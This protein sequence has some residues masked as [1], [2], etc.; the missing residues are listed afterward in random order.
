MDV[1]VQ[2][3]FRAVARLRE[4][5]IAFDIAKTPWPKWIG[6]S[7][8]DS[9]Q[10]CFKSWPYGGPEPAACGVAEVVKHLFARRC[11]RRSRRAGPRFES[12]SGLTMSVATHCKAGQLILDRFVPRH[13]SE[14]VGWV[15]SEF[16]LLWLA[17]NTQVPLT[18]EKV[19]GWKNRGGT[20]LIARRPDQ[21]RLIG[22]GELNPMKGCAGHVWLGHVVLHP[23]ARGA[24]LGRV[25]VGALLDHA[26]DGLGA[27]RVSLVVFPE[28]RIAVRCYESVGFS[29]I[30][31]EH[32]H[33]STS[34]V[35]H[36]LL[37][38]EAVPPTERVPETSAAPRQGVASRVREGFKRF[39]SATDSR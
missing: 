30:G 19:I 35:R 15:K 33:F 5:R 26:F 3:Q 11:R 21:T 9:L 10:S 14:I 18:E 37:R 8:D 22:Y 20:A 27:S 1:L 25:F 13:A 24:G 29:I 31:E 17:P 23:R 34:R 12:E 28:N 6:R 2:I 36:R 4:R 38:L 7:A 16:E 32:H 39:V